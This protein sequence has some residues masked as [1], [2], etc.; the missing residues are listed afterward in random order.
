MVGPIFDTMVAHYLLHPD[1]NRRSMDVLAENELG[2]TPMSITELIG[3][4]GK[5][6]KSMRE[7]EIPVVCEYACEDTDVTLQL[8]EYFEP[9]LK[10]GKEFDIF[11]NVEMPL[12]PVLAEMEEE[13][14]NL[15]CR[16]IA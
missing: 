16:F 7:V 8:K 1:N 11:K 13:G 5:N 4:K 15:G 3:K 10:K 2:Y 14:V 9:E 6:Q 12:I